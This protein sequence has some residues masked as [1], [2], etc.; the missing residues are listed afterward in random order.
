MERLIVTDAKTQKTESTDHTFTIEHHN[1]DQPAQSLNITINAKK[2]VI[3]L[4]KEIALKLN[5]KFKQI[6]LRHNGV[7]L[8]ELEN[9]PDSS[10]HNTI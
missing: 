10:I 4:K 8:M 6:I 9:V 7:L 3:D 2:L 1:S 5:V